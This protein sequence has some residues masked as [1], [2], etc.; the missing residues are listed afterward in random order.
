MKRLL[1]IAAACLIFA[2]CGKKQSTVELPQ[3]SDNSWDHQWYFY[4][5]EGFEKTSLPQKSG[6]SSLKPWT[7]TLRTSAAN[8]DA[9][10]NG[11]LVVNRMGVIFFTPSSE[12]FLM[13]D[14]QLFSSSTASTLIFA[15]KDPYITLSRSSFFNKDAS[16]DASKGEDD[17]NRPFLVRIDSSSRSFYPSVTYGDLQLASGGEITGTH[18]DGK[19][20]LTSIKSENHGKTYFSYI[21]F[22]ANES[23]R[24]ASPFTHS[25]K[26]SISSATENDYRK[27]NSPARYSEAPG[28]LKK[29]L[30]SI[31]QDFNFAIICKNAGGTSPRLYTNGAD[32]EGLT[33]ANAIITDGWICA[34]F[35]DGT[36]YFNGALQNRTVLNEGKNIAFRL[37]KLPENYMYG[38]FC[39]S[40]NKL[41][42]S[43]E[44]SD[45]YKTGRSGFL[46][47][48]LGKVLYGDL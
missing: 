33:I 46:V 8:T 43:W 41:A 47:V 3:I 44:E 12:P 27:V 17:R 28:R 39:I 20:F 31:P 18:F 1:I 30:S 34:V 35:S 2:S 10:G 23:L 7:E 37:P 13:Q 19:N 36:T 48:D 40:G 26:V 25:G 15:E 45:F 22:H 21:S 29:L 38:D 32:S 5:N 9:S 6:I 14:Y 4:T 42:V 11:Y 16:L 24:S